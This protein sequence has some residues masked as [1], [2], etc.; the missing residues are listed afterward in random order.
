MGFNIDEFKANG[1][2]Y[3]G[4]RPSLFQIALSP[5]PGLG[6]DLVSAR[7]LELTAK[8]ASLPESNLGEILIPYFG[9]TVKEPGDRTFDDWSVTIM[10]DED[11]GVRAMFEKWSN[12]MNRH[13]SNTRQA[14]LTSNALKADA[15]VIQYGKDQEVIRAYSMIGVWPR[16]VAAIDLDWE[17]TNAFEVFQVTFSY[18]LWE[19]LVEVS[20]KVVGGINQF[21]GDL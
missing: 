20:S 7:K 18:D 15:Q 21:S 8:G 12:Q 14:G 5:P 13:V 19:P 6:L 16:V 9:R 1:L 3:G 17:T 2:I 4:A 10:N 11:F